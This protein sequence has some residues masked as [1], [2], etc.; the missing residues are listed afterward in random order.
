MG[1][2]VN[3]DPASKR[4]S[5]KGSSILRIAAFSISFFLIFCLLVVTFWPRGKG[6]LGRILFPGGAEPAMAAAENLVDEL[7]NGEAV[8]VALEN[9]CRDVIR[10]GDYH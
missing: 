7:R 10:S 9:F 2:Q 1:Y 3:Y 6:A 8:S 4:E 5:N